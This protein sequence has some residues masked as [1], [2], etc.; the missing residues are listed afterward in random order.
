MPGFSEIQ[1]TAS[2]ATSAMRLA[3]AAGNLEDILAQAAQLIRAQEAASPLFGDDSAGRKYRHNYQQ[4]GED[5]RES[6]E[7]LARALAAIGMVATEA[8][9]GLAETD[10]QGARALEA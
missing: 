1:D 10:R 4:T 7:E 3:S 2:A 8:V 6:V 5:V 9:N